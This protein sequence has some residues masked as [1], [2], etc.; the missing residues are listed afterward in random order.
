M[1]VQL[2]ING[3]GR[4]GRLVLRAAVGRG[5]ANVLAINDPFLTPD[6]ARYLL[7][8]DTAHGR[9]D[10]T[11]ETLED[12][13]LVNGKKVS[14]YTE[15]DHGNIKWGDAGVTDVEDLDRGDW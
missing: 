7:S 3:F 4:I 1:S 2:G 5:C 8:Y 11:V 6:Y 15:M 14:F 10:G 12:G 9:F 13:L